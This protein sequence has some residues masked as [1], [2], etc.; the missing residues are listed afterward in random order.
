ML[1]TRRGD[2]HFSALFSNTA[3]AHELGHSL[4]LGHIGAPLEAVMS[5]V[6]SGEHR[7]L[8]PVD[9][10]ALCSVWGKWPN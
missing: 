3:L 4:G 10:A 7:R 1:H 5:P 6:Y 8:D 2:W 9:S